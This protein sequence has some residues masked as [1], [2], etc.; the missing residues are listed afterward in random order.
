MKPYFAC[1]FSKVNFS[2][3]SFCCTDF[4]GVVHL[5][6]LKRTVLCQARHSQAD[7]ECPGNVPSPLPNN[8]IEPKESP[9]EPNEAKLLSQADK[10][11]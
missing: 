4:S 6:A 2:S 7:R 5:D 9:R 8:N 3:D 11:P 10:F 1:V